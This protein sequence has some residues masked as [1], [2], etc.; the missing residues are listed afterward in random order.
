VED[1]GGLPVVEGDCFGRLKWS[2]RQGHVKF[3][4]SVVRANLACPR[5]LLICTTTRSLPSILSAKNHA[6]HS[7]THEK[8]E[9]IGRRAKFVTVLLNFWYSR[10]P[11]SLVYACK[12]WE[13]IMQ[14]IGLDLGRHMFTTR[15][16]MGRKPP[17]KIQSSSNSVGVQKKLRI[18]FIRVLNT[19]EKN[20]RKP[21]PILREETRDFKLL[22]HVKLPNTDSI[23]IFLRHCGLALH[24]NYCS[25]DKFLLL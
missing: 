19:S 15:V 24:R 7:S 18:I 2:S 9:N 4:D 25:R 10:P 3:S 13:R 11:W 5:G 12:F 14:R 20:S 17:F 22:R 8:T 1:G 21:V 6:C 23:P 16:L